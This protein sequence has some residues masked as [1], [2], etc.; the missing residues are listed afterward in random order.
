MQEARGDGLE[1]ANEAVLKSMA[2]EAERGNGRFSDGR[3]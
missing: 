2:I 1:L 3:D